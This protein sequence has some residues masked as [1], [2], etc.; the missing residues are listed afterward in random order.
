MATRAVIFDRDGVL[1]Y[2]DVR[3]AMQLVGSLAGIQFDQL[4]RRW[5]VWCTSNAKPTT[6]EGEHRFLSRF[7][8]DVVDACSLGADVRARLRAFDYTTMI[9]S[10]DDARPALT[11]L[12]ASGLRIGVLSNFPMPSIHASL[13]AV[14]LADL[15]DVA[16]SASAIGHAKPAAEAYLHIIR[17]LGVGP[18]ETLMVDNEIQNVEGAR[19]IGMRAL[20][21]LRGTI[22]SENSVSDLGFVIDAIERD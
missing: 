14:G 2:F 5:S 19:A 18:H 17:M 16:V 15:I 3:P 11:A 21:V 4:R 12:R 9:R 8:D 10:F 1:T 7:W 6:T 20:H 22:G 13:E